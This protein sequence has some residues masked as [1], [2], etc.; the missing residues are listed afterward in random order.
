MRPIELFPITLRRLV[1]VRTRDLTP[2]MRRITLTGE[3]L[4]AHVSANGIAVPAFES[5]GF[6]DDIKIFLK[7][8]DADE[9]VLPVQHEGVL[10]WP[11]DPKLIARTYTVRRWDPA[12]RELDVDFVVHGHGPA[13]S[14]AV[15][16][17]PGDIVHIAGPTASSGQPVGADWALIGGDETAL[18]AIGRWLEEWPAGLRAQIFIEIADDS[19][20]QDLPQPDGVTITWLNRN[21]APA[22]ST[23]L[24]HDAVTTAEWWDGTPYVW[25]IGEI[26]TTLAT[27][28]WVRDI[29][30][31][32]RD[33]ALVGGYWRR[34]KQDAGTTAG[35][36]DGQPADEQT[37]DETPDVH[38]HELGGIIGGFAV[39]VAATIGLGHAL[40]DGSRTVDELA[41]A[42]SSDPV[43]VTKLLRYLTAVGL[44]S[45]ADGR[46][47][48]TEAGHDLRADYYSD[49]LD[50]NR[51]D[52]RAEVGAALSLLAAVRTGSGDHQRWFG[53]GFEETVLSDPELL[54]QRIEHETAE[55]RLFGGAVA[56]APPLT[57]VETLVIAG[58]GAT[59][60][61]DALVDA[62][63]SRRITVVAAPSEVAALRSVGDAT[64]DRVQLHAGSL[65]EPRPVPVDAVLL[66]DALDRHSDV[67]AAHV[68][69]QAAASVHD[70]GAVLV[71]T[72]T[73][74]DAARAS[75]HDYE[76]DLK[77]FA[78]TGGGHRTED[79]LRQLADAADLTVAERTPIAWGQ[80]LY[81]LVPAPAS[82][83]IGR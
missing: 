18:P 16:A 58:V 12:S 10:D 69:R 26:V 37:G 35:H 55:G 43:G 71:L 21:G 34:P 64:H 41:A 54:T 65:L 44:T 31:L 23:T 6:D 80:A 28:R 2:G 38:L 70:G 9:P 24:L 32:P 36:D 20:R 53:S 8:P 51:L 42:C 66:C 57:G 17:Q 79:E 63:P 67:D 56:A 82:A 13:T 72:T 46:Y 25:V 22:G 83:A 11:G 45:V 61:A 81:R 62:H 19:R 49:E 30:G 40:G 4:D 50:F 1:V 7:H 5:R 77:Q 59:A 3:D 14:W 78:L 75:A 48:L 33:Q 74:I 27:R 68:L 39:R 60:Y 47:A 15:A 52:G 29:K 73:A 76:H